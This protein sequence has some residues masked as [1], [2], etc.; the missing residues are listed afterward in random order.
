MKPVKLIMSAFGPYADHT[1]IDF[2]R[3]GGQGLYL[4]TGDTG[5]GKTTIFDAIVF[6][7]YGEASGDVRKADMF[8]SKYAKEDV[9]TFVTFTFEYRGKRYQVKRNPEY[10]RPKGRGTGYTT[11]KA[12]AELVYPDDRAPVTKSKDVT[13]AVTDLIGLDRR[14]FTQIAMIAQGDFQKLL[15]AGTEERGAIFRQIF[16]TGLYQTLQIKLKEATRIQ[17]GEYTELKRSINQYMESIVCTQDTPTAEKMRQLRR[18]KFDGRV[19]EGLE[20]LNQLCLE[21]EEAL[22]ALENEISALDKQIESENQ[23]IGNIHKIRQQQDELAKNQE[24]LVQLA[25]EMQQMEEHYQEAEQNAA[26]CGQLAL[27]IKE[28]QKNLVLFDKLDQTEKALAA[29]RQSVRQGME[30][31]LAKTEQ[32]QM[33][34]RS[35]QAD[36]EALREL[37]LAGEEKARLENSRDRI[38]EQLILLQ[39]QKKSWEQERI[40]QQET[41]KDIGRQQERAQMLTEQLAQLQEQIVQLSD[42][43]A[44]LAVT[45]ELQGRMA[46][47]G[48]LLQQF[49]QERRDNEARLR[50]TAGAIEEL[51]GQEAA[52]NQAD[53]QRRADLEQVK[54]A[55]EQEIQWQH[56]LDTA[57][58]QLAVFEKQRDSLNVLAKEAAE[59]QKA[60]HTAQTQAESHQRQQALWRSEW[61]NVKDADTRSLKLA[62]E[63]KELSEQ[64]QACR[65]LTEEIK[66]WEKLAEELRAAQDAYQQ[67]AAQKERIGADYRETE[68]RFLDAQA[69]MLAR[70]LKEGMAC[71][72]CGA[73]HHENLARM[74]EKTPEKAEVER[75]KELL[76]DAEKKAEGLSVTAGHLNTRLKEQKQSIDTMETSIFGSNDGETK[77]CQQDL[78]SPDREQA[79]A[80]NAVSGQVQEL[81]AEDVI[82]IAIVKKNVSEKEQQLINRAKKLSMA[83]KDTEKEQIRKA[84]LDRLIKEGETVQGELNA[85]LQKE[86]QAFAAAQGKLDEKRRQWEQMLAELQLSDTVKKE[87]NAI[88]AYLGQ[89]LDVCKA[90]LK[91]AATAK[92]RQEELV[93]EAE[94]G[95]EQKR[96]LQEQIGSQT[97]Q[98]AELTGQER[99]L[100]KQAAVEL[101]KA[102]KLCGEAA[103]HIRQVKALEAKAA[104]ADDVTDVTMTDKTAGSVI[105]NYQELLIE[106]AGLLSK[107]ITQRRQLEIQQK[108]TQES[109]SESSAVIARLEKELE[110]VR[111]LKKEKAE[112]LFASLCEQK[113]ELAGTQ[114]DP[115]KMPAEELCGLCGC[116][117]SELEQQRNRLLEDLEQNRE[118]L[119]RKQALEQKLPRTEEEIK[120]LV[121]DI[122]KAEVSLT[123]QT[124]ECQAMTNEID[125]LQEQLGAEPKETVE[126]HIQALADQKQALETAFRTAKEQYEE[127]RS[128]AGH[129]TAAVETLKKQ[130]D[131]AGEAAG[132]KEEEVLAR[133]EKWQQDK[134][135][136]NI[137]RDQKNNAVST[138]RD[139]YEKVMSRQENILSVEKKY[140]WIK[141]LSDTANGMLNGK[142]KV[143]LETYIQMTYFDRILRRANLRL[144]TMSSGQ[145]E[146]KR[147]ADS[148]NRREKAGLDLCVIDHYNATERSVKTLS[149]GETFEASLSLALG[150]S[151][152]IQSY[153]GG[154]QMDSM[155]VD[156]GFG[157][158][159]EEALAQAMKALIHLTEGNRLVGV[160]SHVSELKDQIERKLVVTKNRSRDGVSSSVRVE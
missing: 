65:K 103:S 4:I 57:K 25:P 30:Q 38:Q 134:R 120:T 121:Q 6:A 97:T 45:E 130:L 51:R 111:S 137:R 131:A 85:V 110:V 47:Q 60:C 78:H 66:E 117:V 48:R 31:K 127:Y 75:K 77:S 18:E 24:L 82:Y 3:L 88:A 129:L 98:Q 99:T 32:Q 5:A 14:Q 34:E 54:S 135:E 83:I 125:N 144:M 145:Y 156:E 19:G 152:E 149:G 133:R 28:R 87:E 106:C 91:Q 138:N 20:L 124:A 141:A 76:T 147:E 150:L 101:E 1:E 159:D 40:R 105:K 23:L 15:L 96:K 114:P 7:L 158:L 70:E 136:R 95:E 49:E 89:N 118:K 10:Q 84:E 146:L 113:P 94:Q 148:E 109:V 67:A 154:I 35:F 29:S 63:Q 37:A 12:E 142:Q 42:R 9:P 151:D 22:N 41:E 59:R 128:R 27:E 81:T 58:E 55:G 26:V 62:Q 43:D 153:A 79:D 13:R 126:R 64:E 11:Q 104:G 157:S 52:L 61:E 100:A 116:I 140:I 143:E 33:L 68:Q 123:K 50:Q 71:P 36:S 21:D 122:Q 155:F 2:E 112:Q 44:I 93:R 160:I 115:A 46:E 39:R 53:N 132:L 73:T 17:W 72:V 119:V 74:P 69:G 8:R 108:Q 16:K 56:R 80:C 107:S 86:N 102:E 92:A 90:Q 139:I